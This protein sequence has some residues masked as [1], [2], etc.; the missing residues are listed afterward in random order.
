MDNYMSLKIK[1]I[2]ANEA[3]AR[4]VAAA[5]CVSLDPTI[6]QLNDV[7][8]A[9]SEAVTNSIVHGYEGTGEGEIE[10]KAHIDGRILHIEVIDEGVGIP[11]IEQARQPFYTTKPDEERSGMG[12]TVMESFMDK[13]E[14]QNN[15]NRGVIV[16]MTKNLGVAKKSDGAIT[17]C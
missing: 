17:S 13:L 7:K 8:T 2:S 10:I 5:F 15:G 1:A 6:D 16:I 12:F 3:F 11:D 4:S 14:I 9:V